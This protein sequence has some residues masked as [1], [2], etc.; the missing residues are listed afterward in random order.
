[1][2][3]FWTFH[4]GIRNSQSAVR[5]SGMCQ[6]GWGK[7]QRED[8]AAALSYLHLLKTSVCIER[9]R[10]AGRKRKW[11]T[12]DVG[13]HLCCFFKLLT[14][15]HETVHHTKFP[16][17]VGYHKST[18]TTNEHLHWQQ[19]WWVS[20][21]FLPGNRHGELLLYCDFNNFFCSLSEGI[22]SL[23]RVGKKN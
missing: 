15:Q 12:E 2:H 10:F 9:D 1:M 14:L 3:L 4:V 23:R 22:G 8:A 20:P 7:F 21:S 6:H 18:T 11:A 5:V 17:T 16:R 13:Q 19:T